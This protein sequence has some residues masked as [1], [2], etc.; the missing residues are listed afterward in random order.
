[1]KTCRNVALFTLF[2][3][4][5][6]LAVYAQAPAQSPQIV[7]KWKLNLAKS[8]F[9]AG[10]P[11]RSRILTWGWDGATLTHLNN[12]VD[13]KGVASTARFS[14]KFDGKEVPVFDNEEKKPARYVKMKMIDPYTFEATNRMD[15]KDL[16]T[17]RHTI[18]QDGKTDTIVQAGEMPEGGSG[19][20]VLLYDKQ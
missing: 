9:G 17:Y 18:S 4:S 5:F 7:G 6:V 15:G 11:Y 12:T 14:V 13:A 16:A 3:I 19:K 1:M 8:K 10:P 20:D 2:V